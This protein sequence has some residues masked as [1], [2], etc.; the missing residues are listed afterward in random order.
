MGGTQLQT[1]WRQQSLAAKSHRKMLEPLD[2]A[3][4]AC[5]VPGTD[6]AGSACVTSVSVLCCQLQV[7]GGWKLPS[8]KETCQVKG[9]GPIPGDTEGLGGARGG[10]ASRAGG[11]TG[12]PW[13]W[14]ESM[15]CPGQAA[16]THTGLLPGCRRMS[17][18]GDQATAISSR[19]LEHSMG[20][21]HHSPVSPLSQSG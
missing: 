9:H 3:A 14:R 2:G 8:H 16:S 20:R 17:Q 15:L 19:A 13:G 5:S 21:K 4:S 12:P 1:H 18:A 7:C 6:K 10:Q 11:S